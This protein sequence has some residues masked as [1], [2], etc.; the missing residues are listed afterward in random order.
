MSNYGATKFL[1]FSAELQNVDGSYVLQENYF[2]IRTDRRYQVSGF[3]C[4][5]YVKLIQIKSIGQ[6]GS[7]KVLK[8]QNMHE[9]RNYYELE[10]KQEIVEI[11][12]EFEEALTAKHPE[13][14][15]RLFGQK[16][17]G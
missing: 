1:Q 7:V 3:F 14:I 2:R 6:N 10:Q 12:A 13:R 17:P 5:E 11:V 8:Y 9:R 15:F 4:A 16:I